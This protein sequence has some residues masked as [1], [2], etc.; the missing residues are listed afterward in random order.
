MHWTNDKLGRREYGEMLDHVIDNTNLFRKVSDESLVVAIN[1]GYGSGKTTFLNMWSNHLKERYKNYENMLII[2]MNAW[3]SDDFENALIPFIHCIHT[4]LEK[5]KNPKVKEKVN[6]KVVEGFQK[7]SLN[8]IIRFGRR[9]ID[10]TM[11]KS[12]GFDTNDIEEEIALIQSDF[13]KKGSPYYKSII[14]SYE[15]HLNSKES[16]KKALTNISEEIPIVILVDELDRCRP[17][18]A[19]EILEIIKHYFDVPNLIYVFAL[20]MEQ[21]SHSIGTIYGQNMDAHGYLRKFFDVILS[22]PK[23]STSEYLEF[24]YSDY[25]KKSGKE[26]SDL[27]D[28][29]TSVMSAASQF[30]LSL[31]EVDALLPSIYLLSLKIS[32]DV[33]SFTFK[34]QDSERNVYSVIFYL[35][36]MK[37]KQQSTYDYM[38]NDNFGDSA[39]SRNQNIPRTTLGGVGTLI[40]L[41]SNGRNQQIIVL[42]HFEKEDGFKG[43]FCS[44]LSFI[45]EKQRPKPTSLG[46]LLHNYIE[47][48]LSLVS[49][50]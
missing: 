5:I 27:I 26:D 11:E 1:S 18:Y 13:D 50:F 7:A 44:F 45:M 34:N 39:S 49:E 4:E 22:L 12:L 19:V 24:K 17:N 15:N 43:D 8:S 37:Y 47:T 46:Q 14:S 2:K 48:S 33:N 30:N 32:N 36:F 31:R 25:Q 23:P 38:L 10:H 29:E 21:L 3:S 16:F 41:L 28:I 9:I 40:E 20:D 6:N 35:F 42:Q